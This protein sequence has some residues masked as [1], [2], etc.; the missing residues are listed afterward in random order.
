MVCSACGQTK[1]FEAKRMRMTV[2]KCSSTCI[3]PVMLRWQKTCRKKRWA[4]GDAM[5]AEV[6][7]PMCFFGP[8]IVMLKLE[9][10]VSMSMPPNFNSTLVPKANFWKP[11]LA[12]DDEKVLIDKCWSMRIFHDYTITYAGF[13]SFNAKCLCYQRCFE[14]YSFAN[15][16]DYW[17]CL[18]I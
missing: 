2:H 10:I 17:N 5:Q 8:C 18:C 16:L 14:N 6:C 15:Y 4:E 1:L 3:Q 9:S 12:L 13:G 7:V 11:N